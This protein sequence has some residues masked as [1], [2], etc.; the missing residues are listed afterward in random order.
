MGLEGRGFIVLIWP[1]PLMSK[2]SRVCVAL[3]L[4]PSML[5][6]PPPAGSIWGKCAD[7]FHHLEALCLW[8]D[9]DSHSEREA[10]VCVC[11]HACVC[12]ITRAEI[13]TDSRKSR[14][15]SAAPLPRPSGASCF[16]SS[17]S[18]PPMLLQLRSRV[19]HPPNLAP[20]P[21]AL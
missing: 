8:C 12:V 15:V 2:F 21:L 19:F 18:L 17:S 10:R 4:T 6:P 13:W 9:G 7:L 5:T 3:E 16:S 20:P 14:P 11:L 1:L